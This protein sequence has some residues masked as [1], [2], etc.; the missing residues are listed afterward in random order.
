MSHRDRDR[1]EP[2]SRDRG[3]SRQAYHEN[4]V[5]AA[6]KIFI[7]NVPYTTT[8]EEVKAHFEGCGRVVNVLVCIACVQRCGQA[9]CSGME[10]EMEPAAVCFSLLA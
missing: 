9:S 8:D 3:S 7:G 10:T 2:Y 1:D 6:P 4:K 5:D